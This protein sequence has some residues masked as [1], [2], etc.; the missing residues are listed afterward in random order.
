M[1]IK[2]KKKPGRA[3]QSGPSFDGFLCICAIFVAVWVLFALEPARFSSASAPSSFDRQTAS[4]L[5]NFHWN[6]K[7][8]RE[9]RADQS[10]RNA[11]L[12]G[13]DSKAIARAIEDEIRPMMADIE[14]KS[15]IESEA[16]LK[17]KALDTR[18]ASI[19]LN[20]D[21]IPEVV[22]QATVACSADGNCPFWVFWKS[23][24]G[25]DVILKGE[26]ST[27]AVQAS[28]TNG[29]R[30]IVLSTHGSY[31]SGSLTEYRYR[32]GAYKDVGCYGY[33]WTTREGNAVREL[34]EPRITPCR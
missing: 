22:A 29:F 16:Q 2:P 13:Q 8:R 9:L 7:E 28:S 1:P 32:D 30:D 5:E 31:S 4:S 33:E 21:G 12:A 15:E 14:V 25:Y 6:W 34:K 18:I 26:A 23:K 24:H 3:D 17:K 11:S 19:D 27:F 20:G 10:V